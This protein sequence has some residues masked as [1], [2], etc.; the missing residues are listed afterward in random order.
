MLFYDHGLDSVWS[1]RKDN[2]S[3][4]RKKIAHGHSYDIGAENALW[5]KKLCQIETRTC[6]RLKF[7]FASDGQKKP[8]SH[9]SI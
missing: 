8:L 6:I 4:K 9:S 1:W 5:A 7:A 3:M 2:L